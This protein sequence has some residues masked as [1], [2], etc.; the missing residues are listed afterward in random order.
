[1]ATGAPSFRGISEK[2]LE[3]GAEPPFDRQQKQ[4][5]ARLRHDS[6]LCQDIFT[7]EPIEARVGQWRRFPPSFILV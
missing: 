7:G 2:L 6:L 1:M 3:R 4:K 5:V